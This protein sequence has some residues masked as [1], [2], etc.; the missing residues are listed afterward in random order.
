MTWGAFQ[1]ASIS[2]WWLLAI[3]AVLLSLAAVYFKLSRMPWF[4]SRRLTVC[5][6]L[7]VL[8]HVVLIAAAYMSKLFE[9]PVIAGDGAIRVTWEETVEPHPG[10]TSAAEVPLHDAKPEILADL[11]TEFVANVSPE[12]APIQSFEIPVEPF[13]EALPRRSR[14]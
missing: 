9:L 1:F 5:I 10:E 3:V 13:L 6:V 2:L 14:C 11:A 4:R 8:A 12:E 7:S